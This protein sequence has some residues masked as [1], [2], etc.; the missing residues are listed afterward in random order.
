MP[1]GLKNA[2]QAFQRLMDKVTRDLDFA[3]VYLDDI[4]I[5]SRSRQE[6]RAH[7]RQLFQKL[8]EHG[9]AINLAKCKFGLSSI[10]FLGHRVNH[11]GAVSLLAKV[12]AIRNFGKPTTVKGLQEFVGMVTF[13]HRFVPAAASIMEPLQTPSW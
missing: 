3:F 6:H 7:L 2:A 8:S 13:Y 10:N 5:A 11:H 4:F 1:F 9:L 12:D